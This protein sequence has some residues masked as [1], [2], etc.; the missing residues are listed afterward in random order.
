MKFLLFL[1]ISITGLNEVR[2]KSEIKEIL[3]M[4]EAYQEIKK[5][6]SKYGSKNVLVVFDIDSTL[7]SLNQGLGSDYWFTW[8]SEKLKS[9]DVTD[10][11]ANDVVGILDVQLQL[12]TLSRMHP[13]EPETPHLVSQLQAERIPVMV[14]TSRMTNFRDITEQ[15][16]RESKYNIGTTSPAVLRD[17]GYNYIPYDPSHPSDYGLEIE[18]VELAN[19]K[20]VPQVNYKQG[21]FLTAG[22][23]KGVALKS[24]LGV[25]AKHTN[26]RAI[27]FIDDRKHNCKAVADVYRSSDLE[28]VSLRY[29]FEDQLI[30]TFNKSTKAE[31]INGYNQLMKLK[32]NVFH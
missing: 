2:A 13:P 9:G 5:Q 10:R 16:L 23:H 17:T 22:L 15:H 27:V 7:L 21:V 8:Q 1:L 19:T 26:Y 18:D 14:L 20:Q 4:S 32:E 24:F 29:G 12:Y 28:V 3:R 6:V 11:V 30:E 25:K 31:A